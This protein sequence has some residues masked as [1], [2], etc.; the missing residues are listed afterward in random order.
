MDCFLVLPPATLALFRA[1]GADLNA[2][3]DF[4][5]GLWCL[6]FGDNAGSAGCADG[7]EV[8]WLTDY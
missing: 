3:L 5:T 8:P 2:Q 7:G 6:A 4:R 1:A